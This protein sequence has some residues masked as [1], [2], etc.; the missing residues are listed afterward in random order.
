M[1]SKH[2]LAKEQLKSVGQ[3]A[4]DSAMVLECCRALVLQ[5]YGDAVLL[6]CTAMVLQCF[7]AAMHSMVLQC[8]SDL[9]LQ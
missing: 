1:S 7:G 3:L 9:V 8:C 6:C 2:W 5:C 4:A